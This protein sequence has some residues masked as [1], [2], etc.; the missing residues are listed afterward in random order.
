MVRQPR[1]YLEYAC[2]EILIKLLQRMAQV[3]AQ[4]HSLTSDL[5]FTNERLRRMRRHKAELLCSCYVELILG[6]TVVSYARDT[7]KVTYL[8]ASVCKQNIIEVGVEL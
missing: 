3:S 1:A 8:W 5:D 6:C 4:S 2:I 7:D